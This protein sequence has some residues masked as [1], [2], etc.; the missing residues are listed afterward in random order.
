MNVGPY[1]ILGQ[2]YQRFDCLSVCIIYFSKESHLHAYAYYKQSSVHAKAMERITSVCP[3]AAHPFRQVIH[4]LSIARKSIH[5]QALRSP[6]F[7]GGPSNPK[8]FPTYLLHLHL[9]SGNPNGAMDIETN[10]ISD[11]SFQTTPILT[12]LAIGD[13][14]VGFAWQ[15]ISGRIGYPI[16]RN[17]P[18]LTGLAIAISESICVAVNIGIE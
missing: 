11:L 18:I 5:Y 10:R 4:D 8:A 14:V 2:I 3:C 13:R 12:G 1:K 17:P 15:W 6:D 16:F 7:L 9:W